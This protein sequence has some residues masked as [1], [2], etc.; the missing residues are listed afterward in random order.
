MAFTQTHQEVFNIAS[1][2]DKL[3]ARTYPNAVAE[4]VPVKLYGETTTDTFETLS[5]NG[6]A[7]SVEERFVWLSLNLA[8]TVTETTATKTSIKSQIGTTIYIKSDQQAS[9]LTVTVEVGAK[10]NEWHK[11][12]GNLY[13]S[14]T[15]GTDLVIVLK[16][17]STHLRVTLADGASAPTNVTATVVR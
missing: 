9:G 17:K 11:L 6:G 7:L 8:S 16:V 15:D 12:P 1:K 14:G 13:D 4:K 5:S 2:L 10:T 3:L